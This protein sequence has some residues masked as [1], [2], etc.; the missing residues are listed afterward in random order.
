MNL[1]AEFRV[2]HR[3]ANFSAYLLADASPQAGRE[4]CMVEMT[5]AW[6]DSLLRMGRAQDLLQ[7]TLLLPASEEV[8]RQRAAAEDSLADVTWH[9]IFPAMALGTSAADAMHKLAALLSAFH[10][11]LGPQLSQAMLRATVRWT[12][13]YGTEHGFASLPKVSQSLI[14]TRFASQR[15]HTPRRRSPPPRTWLGAHLQNQCGLSRNKKKKPPNNHRGPPRS[16]WLPKPRSGSV[17]PEHVVAELSGPCKCRVFIFLKER[18]RH[19][20]QN[21]HLTRAS[22]CTC[23]FL[24]QPI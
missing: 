5:I 3:G 9:H 16:S 24:P 7:Q 21:Y 14:A 18:F 1:A 10:L 15:Q 12:T 19:R 20:L 8:H 2:R 13:D 22:P 11:D 17:P 23:A 6:E 4:W